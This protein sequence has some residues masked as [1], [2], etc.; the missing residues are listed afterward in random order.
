M[1]NVAEAFTLK[2]NFSRTRNMSS[3]AQHRPPL[4]VNNS[5]K[6][7]AD[8]GGVRKWFSGSGSQALMFKEADKLGHQFFVARNYT[9][10]NGNWARGY[11]YSTQ[12]FLAHTLG[13]IR[14]SEKMV[15]ITRLSG[16]THNCTSMLITT[17]R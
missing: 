17:L 8:Q 3:T 16:L 4:E 13:K 7:Q 12:A 14:V 1:E 10:K 6:T 5:Y 15:F 9:Y 2:K 11:E